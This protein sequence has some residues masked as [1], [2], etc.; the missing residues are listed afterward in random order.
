LRLPRL[1]PAL[2]LAAML[3]L[4]GCHELPPS[5]PLASLTPV[6]RAGY[7]VFQTRC[8][9]CHYANSQRALHGP[10]LQGIFKE[11]YLPSGQPANDDRVLNTVQHGRGNMPPFGNLLDDSQTTALLAY[12]HTL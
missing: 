3:A 10:G 8:A 6:E 4:G 9:E 2:A 12:L 1:I 5:K 11:R 7:N